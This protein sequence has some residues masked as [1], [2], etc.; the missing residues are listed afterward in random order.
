MNSSEAE[1]EARLLGLVP[2][3]TTQLQPGFL[4]PAHPLWVVLVPYGL[5]L[6]FASYLCPT[7]CLPSSLPLAPL[8]TFLGTNFNFL[9][10]SISAVAAA[11][12]VG[13]AVQAYY[14]ARYFYHLNPLTVILWTINVFFFGIFGFF[15]L[16]FPDLFYFISDEYCRLPTVICIGV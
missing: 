2:A 10:G 6:T 9:M 12:H 1:L 8:A 4:V 13:E 11:L 3:S 16:A 15:P 5:Y 14:L 7:T